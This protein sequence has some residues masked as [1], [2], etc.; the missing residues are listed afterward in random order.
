MSD[1][2]Y[3]VLFLC[4]GNSARSILAESLLR[5]ADER[6]FRAFSAGSHPKGEI[7]PLALGELK[8][9]GLPID[10]LRSKSWHEFSGPDAP[11]MDFVFTVCDSA[12]GEM[13]PFWPGRPVTAHWGIEDP[14][15]VEG[16]EIEKQRAFAQ[17]LRYLKTRI[18]L[19]MNLPIRSLDEMSLQARLREIGQAEGAS[20]P[21]P[22]VA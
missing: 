16:T 7:H 4:T 15:S 18:S 1:H 3:N 17:A 5:K 20:H 22:E 2:I 13:C 8:H 9:A 21:R 19:F 6:R 10:G 11:T 12:A 14:A